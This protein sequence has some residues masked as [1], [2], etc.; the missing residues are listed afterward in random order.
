METAEKLYALSNEP[1]GQTRGAV[2]GALASVSR[3]HMQEAVD[4]LKKVFQTDPKF[5]SPES[6]HTI[7]VIIGT[8]LFRAKQET[9]LK[10]VQ[11]LLVGVNDMSVTMEGYQ[12]ISK[13]IFQM[14]GL[15]LLN[16]ARKADRSKT[17]GSRWNDILARVS[18]ELQEFLK[19]LTLA[20]AATENQKEKVLAREP[21]EIR[22]AVDPILDQTHPD[23]TVG[24]PL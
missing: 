21:E 15:V 1:D 24:I 11:E 3:G 9:V 7:A 14:S 13:Q 8:L 2:C 4:R 10:Q 22:R 19:P 5:L 17:G 23:R 20:I 12:M 16:E 18:L 6:I